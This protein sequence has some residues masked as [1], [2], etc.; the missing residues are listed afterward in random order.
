MSGPTCLR[1]GAELAHSYSTDVVAAAHHRQQIGP[2]GSGFATVLAATSACSWNCLAVLAAQLAGPAADAAVQIVAERER[3]VT[4]EGWT[5]EHDE[6]H[7]AGVLARAA[8]C[9]ADLHV[10]TSWPGENPYEAHTDPD[11][12]PAEAW[13]FDA[14]WWKPQDRLRDLVRAGALV[15]AEADRDVRAKRERF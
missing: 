1:C 13:P 15:A 11:Q 10:D 12:P 6:H 2:D 3:Q 4:A 8:V 7:D 5:P 14:E 9:Y